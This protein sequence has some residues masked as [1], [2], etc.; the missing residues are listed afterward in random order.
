MGMFA[1]ETGSR[2][3]CVSCRTKKT[4]KPHLGEVQQLKH[5]LEIQKLQFQNEILELKLEIQQLKHDTVSFVQVPTPVLSVFKDSKNIKEITPQIK[6]HGALKVLTIE[7]EINFHKSMKQRLDKENN[8]SVYELIES[9]DFKTTSCRIE[10]WK[11]L[12][13]GFRAGL[14]MDNGCPFVQKIDPT[15]HSRQLYD[16]FD[17]TQDFISPKEYDEL[18]SQVDAKYRPNN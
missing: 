6:C 12:Y 15:K 17:G 8:D 9:K 13:S 3:T 14:I 7:D 2:K 10:S 18:V 1:T 4:A 5:D 16:P 11:F